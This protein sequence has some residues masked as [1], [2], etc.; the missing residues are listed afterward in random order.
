MQTVDKFDHPQ[1]RVMRMRMEVEHATSVQQKQTNQR[2]P[3]A[4]ANHM[5]EHIDKKR[6]SD[7]RRNL[8][9]FPNRTNEQ[10]TSTNT[11]SY[12]NNRPSNNTPNETY[13]SPPLPNYPRPVRPPHLIITQ[14]QLTGYRTVPTKLDS[15][16]STSH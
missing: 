4:I 12:Q 1:D 11:H 14:L 2:T 16:K 9:S 6:Q 5:S 7:T 8:D 15:N 10:G 3:Q 13:V